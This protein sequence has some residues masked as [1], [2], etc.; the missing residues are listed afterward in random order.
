[1]KAAMMLCSGLPHATLMATPASLQLYRLVFHSLESKSCLVVV[2]H[3]HLTSDI[4]G[5]LLCQSVQHLYMQITEQFGN[6]V[7]VSGPRADRYSNPLLILG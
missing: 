2:K 6:Q 3:L 5:K 1:M 4:I 7:T